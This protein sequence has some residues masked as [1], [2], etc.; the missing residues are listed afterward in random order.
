MCLRY[1]I[2]AA[3]YT[4]RYSFKGRGHLEEKTCCSPEIFERWVR[5]PH[6]SCRGQNLSSLQLIQYFCNLWK[7]RDCKPCKMIQMVT[8]MCFH[9]LGSIRRF[10]MDALYKKMRTVSHC[11]LRLHKN[12]MSFISVEPSS[13]TSRPF[14]CTMTGLQSAIFIRQK[15][16]AW[17]NQHIVWSTYTGRNENVHKRWHRRTKTKMLLRYPMETMNTCSL[18]LALP[19]YMLHL[20]NDSL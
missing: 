8:Q 4:W 5:H 13:T 19:V 12:Q 10:F 3:A 1:W 18:G 14:T 6:L 17:R 9:F 7:T 11:L 20:K 16:G 2:D 15:C